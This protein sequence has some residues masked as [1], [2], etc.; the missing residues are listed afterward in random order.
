MYDWYLGGTANW[1]VDREFGEKVVN[2]FPVVKPITRANRLFLHR[3]VR[4]LA[5]HGV[6]QFVDIG[7]GVPTMGNTHQ[8][9]DSVAHDCRV[10]YVDNEPVAVAHSEVLLDQH[11]D[12]KRHAVVNADLRD[13]EKLWQRV[14]DTGVVDLAQ[15]VAL[16]LVA[17]LHFRLRGEER[18]PQAERAV[19]R[20]RELLAPGSYLAI[21]HVTDDGVSAG[22]V[23]GLAR[24][25][26][27]YE[28]TTNPVILRPKDEIGALFGD[29]RLL[30]PGMS[31]TAEWHPEETA[32]DAP[33]ITFDEPSDS[34]VW[35]GVAQKS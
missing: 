17:V 13:T 22:N 15:P 19:A 6:R 2:D 3:M 28:H 33:K 25:A 30:E 34:M 26:E 11:G 24:L 27:L 1:A 7:S 8:V 23:T 5:K 29:F 35:V 32:A 21:S 31:W 12:P 9:A 18:D 14:A 10:V 20:Y 4:Y 16:L